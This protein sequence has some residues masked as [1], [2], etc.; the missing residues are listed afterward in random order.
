MHMQVLLLSAVTSGVW[1]S[2]LIMLNECDPKRYCHAN[3]HCGCTNSKKKKK[4]RKK[5]NL[6]V[7]LRTAA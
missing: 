2:A 4:K 3:V 7:L 5:L 6:Q 1:V